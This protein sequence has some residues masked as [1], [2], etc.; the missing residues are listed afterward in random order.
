MLTSQRV[1]DVILKAFGVCAASQVGACD[2]RQGSLGGVG[3]VSRCVTATPRVRIGVNF[4]VTIAVY[5]SRTLTSSEFDLTG[6][7]K[8]GFS[9]PLTIVSSYQGCM[10]NT[11]FGDST[12]AYYET[13]AGGAGAG[14]SW[15]GRSGVHTHMT[16]TRITDPE[17]LERRFPVILERFMLRDGSGGRGKYRGGDGV[18]REM[19]CVQP[20]AG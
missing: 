12:V 19:R 13:V 16:N 10:N 18:V 1:V 5:R 7:C 11:T 2:A 17:V 3:P 14:P 8:A 6:T 15:H 9:T 4:T 20:R